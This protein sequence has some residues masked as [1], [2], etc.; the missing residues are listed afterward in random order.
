MRFAKMRAHRA[1][2]LVVA[3]ASL[4][5]C[6]GFAPGVARRGGIAPLRA[7]AP[8]AA[9]DFVPGETCTGERVA[10]VGA[11]GYIGKAVGRECV[12]RGYATTA[13]VRDA[14]RAVRPL[15]DVWC[16]APRAVRRGGRCGEAGGAASEHTPNV[17]PA[18]PGR[19]QQRTRRWGRS[20]QRTRDRLRG[21]GVV[22]TDA[23]V[24]L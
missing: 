6:A 19:A 2:P 16:H 15:L 22:Q 18:A 10:V 17:R 5:I 9:A 7:A 4:A 1:V 14:S 12:R 13:V 24:L 23:P 20:Q 8:V 11:T 21:S 3:C